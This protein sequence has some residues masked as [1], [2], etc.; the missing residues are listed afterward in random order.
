MIIP[1]EIPGQPWECVVANIFTINNKHYLCIVDY[2]SKFHVL[3]PVE[4]LSTDQLILS[5]IIL[6]S[7]YGLL[8]K[9][10][11]DA[12]TTFISDKCE[13]FDKG[14]SIRH[15]VS[16]SYNHQSNGQVEACVK[17]LNRTILECFDTNT[18]IFFSLL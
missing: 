6:F 7:E 11:S 9:I 14:F 2:C 17:F 4:S 16:S 5:C 12:G 3:K 8:S 10:V 13:N 18:D 1:H 15:T